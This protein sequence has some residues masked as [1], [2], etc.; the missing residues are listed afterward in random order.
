VLVSWSFRFTAPLRHGS[1]AAAGIS[2]GSSRLVE[3][4]LVVSVGCL[5]ASCSQGALEPS[6]S[7]EAPRIEVRAVA[8]GGASPAR[9]AW[10]VVTLEDALNQK[11]STP[12]PT[13]TE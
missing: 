4:R 12:S 2:G 6:E 13:A 5:L 8:S 7:T 10:G 9:P 1:R 3:L 11:A